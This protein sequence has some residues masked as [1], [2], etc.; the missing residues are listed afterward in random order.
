MGQSAL[1]RFRHFAKWVFF[2]GVDLHTRSRYRHL[3][4]QLAPGPIDTLDAGSGNGALSYAAYRRGNR[5]LGLSYNPDE[6]CRATKFFEFLG[7]GARPLQF[8]ALNLYELPS[9]GRRFDQIICSETLEHIRDD[10]RIVTYFYE[11]LRPGGVLH[12]C[13]PYALH[14]KNNLGRV[15]GPEDGGHVRDGY[16]LESYRALL[17]PVGFSIEHS[18]GLG[19]RGLERADAVVRWVRNRFGSSFAVP[20]FTMIWPVL[21]ILDTANPTV[22]LSLYVRAV[23][24][25]APTT[26]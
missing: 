21:P 24:P 16:T 25:L 26:T 18:M 8:Q 14:P 10:K 1:T 12:L 7:D 11:M 15:N 5:V 6:V 13:C 22:P 23:K 20:L 4:R 17:E 2:P 3:A 9:V 19:S